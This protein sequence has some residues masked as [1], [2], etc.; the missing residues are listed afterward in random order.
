MQ[1][2]LSVEEG[3][4]KTSKNKI[5]TIILDAYKFSE[6]NKW[7]YDGYDDIL[8]FGSLGNEG[9]CDHFRFST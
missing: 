4:Y 2:L 3:K 8:C 7:G 6:G 5:N 1:S 9:V